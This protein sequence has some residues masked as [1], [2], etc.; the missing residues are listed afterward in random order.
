M[1]LTFFFWWLIFRYSFCRSRMGFD[2]KKILS[3]CGRCVHQSIY[4]STICIHTFSWTY[5]LSVYLFQLLDL[6]IC[7]NYVSSMNALRAMLL[8]HDPPP[9]L[10]KVKY[11]VTNLTCSWVAL[12][13]DGLPRMR[14]LYYHFWFHKYFSFIHIRANNLK[15]KTYRFETTEYGLS[16]ITML[17]SNG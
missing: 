8:S 16:Q 13:C 14:V 7:I 15:I 3:Q 17:N 1:F 4:L 12:F 10:L 5:P 6:H 9:N 2:W 11:S